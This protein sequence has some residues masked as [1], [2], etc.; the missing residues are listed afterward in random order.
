MARAPVVRISSSTPT[1]TS[2]SDDPSD[3]SYAPDGD[4]DGFVDER[5]LTVIAPVGQLGGVSWPLTDKTETEYADTTD[6]IDPVTGQ[7][8]WSPDT[9]FQFYRQPQPTPLAPLRLPKDTVIDLA[10]SGYLANP[11]SADVFGNVFTPLTTPHVLAEHRAPMILFAPNGAINAAYHW[12]TSGSYGA[13][14]VMNPIFL[15]VGK[16]ERTGGDPAGASL[17]EDGLHNWQDASNLWVAIG[18][19][20]GFV[21]GAEVDTRYLHDNGTPAD[22]SDDYL[23]DN[24]NATDVSVPQTIFDSRRFAREAQISKGALSE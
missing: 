17:A 22:A 18:P 20:S 10:D 5:I 23:A 3:T 16:W 15:M 8:Y 9:T 21:T 19:Q 2:F 12:N 4:G 11:A 6:L 24:V 14:R 13:A 7:I 1:A